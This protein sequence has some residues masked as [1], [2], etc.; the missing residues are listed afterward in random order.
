MNERDF[1]PKAAAD[2]YETAIG[3]SS[4][5]NSESTVMSY[6][7]IFETLWIKSGLYPPN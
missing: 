5:S 1:A 6:A 3:L 2:K 4:Y 7:M